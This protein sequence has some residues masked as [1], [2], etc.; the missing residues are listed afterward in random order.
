MT[1]KRPEVNVGTFSEEDVTTQPDYDRLSAV[2][3]RFLN[4]RREVTFQLQHD[5]VKESLEANKVLA[6]NDVVYKKRL[7]VALSD[8]IV[9]KKPT[10]EIVELAD[11]RTVNP[12]DFEV[13][14]KHLEE[15]GYTLDD[16]VETIPK[17]DHV[18]DSEESPARRPMHYG[19]VALAL[20][21]A[22]I[23]FLVMYLLTPWEK[24]IIAKFSGAPIVVSKPL[25]SVQET[26]P[27]STSAPST[28][29]PV[30]T[31][32][33]LPRS[34]TLEQKVNR[35]ESDINEQSE[36]TTRLKEDLIY[37]LQNKKHLLRDVICSGGRYRIRTGDLL[38]DRETC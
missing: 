21:V 10:Q 34:E 4:S 16:L 29:A 7:A 11:D 23:I 32:V 27:V 6:M 38:R 36:R 14:C 1:K 30:K 31:D 15:N 35:H 24:R 18:P 13:L 2:T 25:P 5:T 12:E 26:P 3:T 19:D 33:N 22:G 17:P 37:P 8:P 9:N 20:G 28:S